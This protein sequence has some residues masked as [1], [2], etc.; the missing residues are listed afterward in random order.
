MA[1]AAKI[2]G[3]RVGT[4]RVTGK[5][6]TGWAHCVQ[7]I[8]V[9]F[10]TRINTR[11]MLLDFG[12]DVPGLI[13]RPGNRETFALFCSAITQALVKWEPGF[14]VTQFSVVDANQDGQ[15]TIEMT[16]IFY[17]RGHLGDYSVSED[18]TTRFLMAAG[19]NGVIFTGSQVS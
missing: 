2:S 19:Q 3:E 6:L 7:S 8:W 9:I 16:G 4:N 13:D 10:T 17:P 14:R 18:A 1:G 11:L 5:L 12:S 15:F